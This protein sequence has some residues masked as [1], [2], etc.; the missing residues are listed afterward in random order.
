MLKEQGKVD[1]FGF[2][3]AL[4]DAGGWRTK[5]QKFEAGDIIYPKGRRSRHVYLVTDGLVVLNRKNPHPTNN[6]NTAIE[7]TT[8][9]VRAGNMFGLDRLSGAKV[10]SDDAVAQR[11]TTVIK[12]PYLRFEE[13]AAKPE[14][15]PQVWRMLK[16]MYIRNEEQNT[17]FARGNVTNKAA[18]ALLEFMED[19]G[20][21]QAIQQEVAR[22]AGMDRV[23]M[24]Y[25]LKRF[26]LMGLLRRTGPLNNRLITILDPANLGNMKKK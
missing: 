7:L 4:A 8:N 10:Y 2:E 5:F 16:S 23:Q 22:L 9:L 19:D 6:S 20:T 14:I 12:I 18:G 1:T 15:L 11:A 26:E 24:N 3:D 21:V 13:F 25:R 17:L